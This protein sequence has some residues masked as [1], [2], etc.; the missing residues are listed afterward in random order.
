MLRVQ[1]ELL[2]SGRY[3]IVQRTLASLRFPVAGLTAAAVQSEFGAARDAGRREHEGIDIFAPRNTPVIAVVDGTAAAG[4]QR[5]RGKRRLAARQ[6][7]A[8]DPSTT[9]T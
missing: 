6:R 8:P 5:A 4:R 3:T 2:R 9:H 1:P 7:P